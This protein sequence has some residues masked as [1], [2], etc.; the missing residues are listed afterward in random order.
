M[1]HVGEAKPDLAMEAQLS[2]TATF[3]FF[4][5]ASWRTP[6]NLRRERP[7]RQ[8]PQTLN[9]LQTF[10]HL[11]DEGHVRVGVVAALFGVSPP[12][13]WRKVRA[14]EFP[15]PIRRFDRV[16]AWRVGDVRLALQGKSTEEK[17]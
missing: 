11:P 1:G 15:K 9:T 4:V 12:T 16:T 2:A 10:S 8:S 13:I 7:M 3:G 17:G 6:L 14:H 5:S